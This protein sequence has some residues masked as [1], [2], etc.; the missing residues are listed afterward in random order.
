MAYSQSAS[1]ESASGAAA[2][3]GTAQRIAPG[4][5]AY[6]E[7]VATIGA[8]AKSATFGLDIKVRIPISLPARA[9]F[10]GHKP[11]DHVFRL[12]KDPKSNLVRDCL[13]YEGQ[14][15]RSQQDYEHHFTTRVVVA[16]VW[17]AAY[18][19][20]IP[21]Y[22][23]VL[24]R[25]I[26]GQMLQKDI[27]MLLARC[28]LWTRAT[29][30]S[31]DE[32]TMRNYAETAWLIYTLR[33]FSKIRPRSHKD[34]NFQRPSWES[35]ITLLQKVANKPF[36]HLLRLHTAYMANQG[37]SNI[38]SESVADRERTLVY[39]YRE[40][41]GDGVEVVGET[42]KQPSASGSDPN[43]GDQSTP[44]KLLLFQDPLVG[45]TFHEFYRKQASAAARPS[46]PQKPQSEEILDCIAVASDLPSPSP[47]P[48]ISHDKPANKRKRSIEPSRS[49]SPK[50]P[51]VGCKGV[52]VPTNP[53]TRRH[54]VS[55][56]FRRRRS[57]P[58]TDS[59]KKF[60][61]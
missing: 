27:D 50:R 8:V 57:T 4:W 48:S 21:P 17:N 13:T 55:A 47:S 2:V 22:H 37:F 36:V 40:Y 59:V 35:L 18:T 44:A 34:S 53:R 42:R 15:P 33:P 16:F 56:V 11:G 29:D 58:P 23:S 28:E 39:F 20:R 38:V 10:L 19:L 12:T 41:N 26:N 32:S 25:W 5:G 52:A 46:S 30:E 60:I 6:Y 1:G 45:S 51:R 43:S 54:T 9:P 31:D 49:S 3:P 7:D 14:I 61:L 24:L